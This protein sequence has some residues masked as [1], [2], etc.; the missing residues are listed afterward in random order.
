MF[1]Q[2]FKPEQQQQ[3]QQQKETKVCKD[4]VVK[5]KICDLLRR[6]VF[7]QQ[8]GAATIISESNSV[9]AVET[10]AS[11]SSSSIMVPYDHSR[12]SLCIISP[13]VTKDSSV[14]FVSNNSQKLGNNKSFM[15]LN[16]FNIKN[17][18]ESFMKI[19]HF[20]NLGSLNNLDKLKYLKNLND[21]NV[22][23]FIN[24]NNFEKVI[25]YDKVNNDTK[26]G[27]SVDD[28]PQWNIK[29]SL[30]EHEETITSKNFE[31]RGTKSNNKR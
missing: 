22:K 25:N 9:A 27:P 18:N 6:M 5:E 23:K 30:D 29:P 19:G 20:N 24:E 21:S 11:N 1:C 16:D 8:E 3:Q 17:S 10:L 7:L 13:I 26:N 28:K 31:I 15:T 2:S 12:K 4:G 14:E